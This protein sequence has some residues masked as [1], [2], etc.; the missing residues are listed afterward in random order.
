MEVYLLFGGIILIACEAA[1][2]GIGFFGLGGVSALLAALFLYLGA[3]ATAAGVV[4]GLTA[5][6]L[7]SIYWL[8]TKFPDSGIG[9]IL[10][11]SLRF[12]TE[13]GYS[14]AEEK[15]EL[16][17]RVGTVHTVMRPAGTVK[18]GDELIDAVSEGGFIDSGTEVV[19]ISVTGGRTVVRSI[20]G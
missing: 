5:V 15:K 12:S 9:R 17:G 6:G 11:L 16:I 14:S 7:L 3:D 13:S 8:I 1:L 2:P 20:D 4:A 18:L 19:V 10:T